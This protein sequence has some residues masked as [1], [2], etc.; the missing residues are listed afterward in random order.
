MLEGVRALVEAG[1]LALEPYMLTP[2]ATT[3][4]LRRVLD[5]VGSPRLG[6]CLDPVNLIEPREYHRAA[7]VLAAMFEALGDRVVAVRAKDHYMHR[8]K[9]TVWIDE[10]VPGQGELPYPALLRAMPPGAA[11]VI[12]HVREDEQIAAARDF[13]RR[14]AE[15]T[16]V[17]HS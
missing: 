12:E 9:A 10:R 1:P 15:E 11:L 3:E 5:E 2:L 7:D 4:R 17:T 6:V 14:I 8:Q 13:I 16:G